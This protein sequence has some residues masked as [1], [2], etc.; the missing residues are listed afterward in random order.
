MLDIDDCNRLDQLLQA[1][2]CYRRAAEQ[3]S[4]PG[5][6]VRADTFTKSI[7]RLCQRLGYKNVVDLLVWYELYF[8]PPTNAE[9][10]AEVIRPQFAQLESLRLR[11]R[12]AL[13]YLA[14]LLEQTRTAP[15]RNRYNRVAV[16]IGVNPR[17]I[18]RRLTAIA[19]ATGMTRTLEWMVFQYAL[20]CELHSTFPALMRPA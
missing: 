5:K 9:K 20:Y 16:Q 10:W 7:E 4:R 8:K 17:T 15:K 1:E 14:L 18:E 19:E 6:V 11:G 2:L 3:I 12:P 13:H